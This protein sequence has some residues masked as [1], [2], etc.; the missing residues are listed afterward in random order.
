MPR[1]CSPRFGIEGI[2]S[3]HWPLQGKGKGDRKHEIDGARRVER[4]K[5]SLKR[6]SSPGVVIGSTEIVAHCSPRSIF[7]PLVFLVFLL[8]ARHEQQRK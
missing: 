5:D 2:N 3:E 1:H 8:L 4:E 6:K 7:F